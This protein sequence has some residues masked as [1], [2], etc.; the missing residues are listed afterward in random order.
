MDLREALSRATV[1][2]ICEALG[3]RS[4]VIVNNAVLTEDED[5]LTI[6]SAQAIVAR[7][8]LSGLVADRDMIAPTEVRIGRRASIITTPDSPADLPG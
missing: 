7:C 5:R 6:H 8:L 1:Q 3:E 4:I 2:E